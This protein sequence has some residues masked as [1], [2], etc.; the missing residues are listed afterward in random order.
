MLKALV[1]GAFVGLPHLPRCRR[2]RRYYPLRLQTSQGRWRLMLQQ[3]TYVDSS[4]NFVAKPLALIAR[5]KRYSTRFVF[6]LTVTKKNT[7]KKLPLV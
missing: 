2:H 1:T 5:N 3:K 7:L 6:Q 4:D